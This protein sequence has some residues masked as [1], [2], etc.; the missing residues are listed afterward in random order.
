MLKTVAIVGRPNVGKSALFN[1][2][3]GKN[4]SIVHDLAGVTRDRITAQCRKGPAWFEIMDTGGIG[5]N[6]EDVLT[7]QV[8][9]EASI[10]LDV[11]DLLLFVVD[12]MDGVT[13]I[14]ATLARELRRTTK[15]VILVCNKADSP[16]R[17]LHSGEFARLGFE[18][19]V[20]VSAAHGKGIDDLIA[21][22]AEKL[23]LKEST[24]TAEA[25]AGDNV[26]PLKLAIV[27]RPNAGKSSL[28]NA[29]LGED[30]AIV[31]EVAGTT[32]DALDLEATYN[33]KRYQLIDTAGIRRRAKLD[34]YVEISSVDRSIQ[35]I[36]R[37]DLVLLV[38]DC[39]DGA[40]MQDRKIAQI[41]METRKPCILVM[42]KWDLFHPSGKQKDRVEHLE[43]MMRRE[44]FFLSYAPLIAISAK[45]KEHIGKLFVQVEKV[46]QGAQNRI[47]TGALNRLLGQ[48]IENTPG[49]LGRSTHSFKLLYATQVNEAA[50]FAIPIPHFVLFANRASRLTEGYTRYLEKVI[51]DEWPAPGVPFRMS[52]RGKGPKKER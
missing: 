36:K 4:I 40:K 22:I 37:A 25:I 1:R 42:N 28:V 9:T 24:E 30:R 50:D 8:Q 19:Y 10:A 6:T 51:R 32:R 11:A 46:R 17:K 20:E 16:S 35:S 39:A 3:A 12:I 29:V 21:M 38:V 14:D 15:P 41:I 18:S 27:G 52:V 13:T 2:L 33:G 49:A 48:A 34:S 23:D 26:R 44:F 43:E 47:S 5:A 45:N 31:S 7:D